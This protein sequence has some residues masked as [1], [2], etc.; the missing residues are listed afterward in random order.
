MF[1]RWCF[2]IPEYQPHN[3]DKHLALAFPVN[4]RSLL[5]PL[6]NWTNASKC[7]LSNSNNKP[8]TNT[9]HR[10]TQWGNGAGE[11]VKKL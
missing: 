3:Q 2:C 7:F 5:I 10:H 4:Y 8:G 9:I 11:R 1:H 6:N